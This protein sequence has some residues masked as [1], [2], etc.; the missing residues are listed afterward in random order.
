MR[1]DARSTLP[2]SRSREPAPKP[3]DASIAIDLGRMRH[4]LHLDDGSG[5]VHAQAGISIETLEQALSVRG[6]TLQGRPSRLG[7]QALG[8]VLADGGSAALEE[9]FL[10]SACIGLSAV[11][12]DGRPVHIK[13]APRRATGPDFLRLFLG[14]RSATGIITAAV[15]RT[16]RQ[17][18]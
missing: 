10:R 14:A 2:S 18:E 4:I 12:A 1:R 9:R 7:T 6:R 11:L 16:R 3:S 8:T 15:L 17:P 13:A 5:T